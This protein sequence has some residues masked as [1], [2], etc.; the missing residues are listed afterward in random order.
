MNK[1]KV[2][3]Y[4]SE[5]GFGYIRPDDGKDD[6]LFHA[7]VL[8]Q[9]GISKLEERQAVRFESEVDANTGKPKVSSIEAC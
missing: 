5:R 6:V 3:F 9:A 7:A 2:R 4:N 8:K 1:G